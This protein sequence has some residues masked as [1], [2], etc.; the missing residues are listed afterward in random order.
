S[1]TGASCPHLEHVSTQ[2]PYA[3]FIAVSSLIGF[4]IG[5]AFLNIIIGWIGAVAVFVAGMVF[6]PRCYKAK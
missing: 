2:M 5:G 6:L 3:L 1:S 4:L